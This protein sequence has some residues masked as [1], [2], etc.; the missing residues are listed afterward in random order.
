[1]T[2][3]T[4]TRRSLHGV[5]ELLLAGPQFT[6]S[7]RIELRVAGAG[8]ATIAAPALAVEGTRL[9]T[10]SGAAD[11]PGRTY[12]EVAAEIG[13]EPRDLADVY[14]DGPAVRADET[15]ELDADAVATLLSA[16]VAGDRALRA[17]APDETPVLWPEHFDVAIT[18][19]AVN[20]GVSPGDG[21]LPEPYAYVGP[22]EPR[23]GEFFNAP[24]GAARPV[25]ELD[26]LLAFFREGRALAR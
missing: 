15:I 5:A 9:I 21:F 3:L 17:L 23:H 20:Y 10:S 19:D 8:F 22:H 7:E 2:A 24:F 26:D 11:L 12:R 16:F 13:V 4:T 18:L 14:T 6:T 25:R 1:M